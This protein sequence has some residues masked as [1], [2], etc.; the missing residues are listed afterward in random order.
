MRMRARACSRCGCGC[1]AVARLRGRGAVAGAAAV[2]G[3]GC[4]CG[5][6]G[7]GPALGRFAWARR[8]G[9]SLERVAWAQLGLRPCADLL[10]PSRA[11]MRP[12]PPMED[13]ALGF[14]PSGPPPHV[15]VR[16]VLPG[17][18]ADTR[19]LQVGDRRL[20]AGSR[21]R[22]P[23]SV[24]AAQWSR[25]PA[26][27]HVIHRI[28]PVLPSYDAVDRFVLEAAYRRRLAGMF[29]GICLATATDESP[30]SGS[31]FL[32]LRLQ[33]ACLYIGV[34]RDAAWRGHD[35]PPISSL[36]V[37]AGICHESCA[38]RRQNPH[39]IHPRSTPKR[40]RM[41]PESTPT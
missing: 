7:V 22:T 19:G 26:L 3:V 25:I 16:Q 9:A 39:R 37:L 20:G 12:R 24:R 41:E 1:G 33:I 34:I 38:D 27:A 23:A 32:G 8:L 29:S 30:P 14:L 5:C 36:R 10:V 31:R 35:E 40:P 2:A 4:G 15:V 18:W 28:D 13:S 17:S 6:A 21:A 11:S